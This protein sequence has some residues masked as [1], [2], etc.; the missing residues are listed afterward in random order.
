[1]TEYRNLTRNILRLY[2]LATPEEIEAGQHWY[3]E[4]N[5]LCVRLSSPHGHTVPQV[6]CA[7]AHLSPRITW[8]QNIEYIETMAIGKPKPRACLTRSWEAGS[9]A[10]V[11]DDPLATFSRAALKTGAF[12][13]AIL[14]D[15]NAVVVDVWSARAAGVGES[16]VRS[17]RGYH[18]VAEAYR[19]GATRERIAARDLQAI[20][21]VHVR[22]AAA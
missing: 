18:A 12:A 6:A 20:V 2:R 4:A 17:T 13:R 11:S 1:M 19:R 22:G 16:M 5:A 10:L 9:R 7:L 14:G 21:W 15:R 8:K 3:D